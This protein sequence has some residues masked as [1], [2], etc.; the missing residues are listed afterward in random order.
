MCAA[1]NEFADL[2]REH[3][4]TPHRSLC[5]DGELPPPNHLVVLLD[6]EYSRVRR[7]T[8]TMFQ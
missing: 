1:S 8:G 6:H 5:G 7:S 2:L 4:T 3:L